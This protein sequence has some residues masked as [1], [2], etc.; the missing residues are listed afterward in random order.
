MRNIP[1]GFE[2]P[3]GREENRLL[4]Q[5]RSHGMRHFQIFLAIVI[6]GICVPWILF[7]IFSPQ[8]FWGFLT[9]EWWIPIAVGCGIVAMLQFGWIAAFQAFGM[10][11]IVATKQ[12]LE[13]VRE[14]RP[15]IFKRS[16]EA[17][18]IKY[19]A[20][21]KDGGQQGRWDPE[22]DSFP[23][24]TLVAQG[25]KRLPLLVRQPLEKSDWLGMELSEW[26]RVPNVVAES[27]E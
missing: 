15:L 11:T 18:Q 25:S 13:V 22:P 9:A 24:W 2:L 8:G 7:G 1:K 21:L 27:R 4:I 19:F 5:Y 20:Q 17:N 6:L 23:S 16:M 10:T 14:L 3:Q 12:E 26:Y